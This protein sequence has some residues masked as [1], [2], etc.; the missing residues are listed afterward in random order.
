MSL[1]RARKLRK[2]TWISARKGM[3]VGSLAFL[4]VLTVALI[5]FASNGTLQR[6][7]ESF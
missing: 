7:L 3:P 4:L 2:K 6:V 5:W 1:I